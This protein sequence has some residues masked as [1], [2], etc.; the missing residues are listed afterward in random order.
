ME[1]D[2]SRIRKKSI[3]SV[4]NSNCP[5][6]RFV[7]VG[8]VGS[9]HNFRVADNAPG[10][11]RLRTCS[12]FVFLSQGGIRLTRAKGRRRIPILQALHGAVAYAPHETTGTSKLDRPLFRRW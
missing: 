5:I 4:P 3:C 6:F 9:D 12:A 10:M 7:G 11:Y 1:L 8:A 2:S